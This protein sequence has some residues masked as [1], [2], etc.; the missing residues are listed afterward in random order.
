MRRERPP[1]PVGTHPQPCLGH[2]LV[3]PAIKRRLLPSRRAAEVIT[4]GWRRALIA[5]GA[6]KRDG[7]LFLVTVIALLMAKQT[8]IHVSGRLS[9]Q[10]MQSCPAV[11]TQRSIFAERE[12]VPPHS[13]AVPGVLELGWKRQ[14]LAFFSLNST[15]CVL[16][17]TD[18]AA[19]V[20]E[21]KLL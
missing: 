15:F 21:G 5:E 16:S 17:N 19:L 1:C 10:R 8:R 7:S 9:F 11:D 13:L 12:Q 20:S 6:G 14:A 18:E 3:S 4:S 2:W